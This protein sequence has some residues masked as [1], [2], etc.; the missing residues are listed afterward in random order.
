MKEQL[1]KVSGCLATA[2]IFS[3]LLYTMR[4]AFAFRFGVFGLVIPVGLLFFVILA[5]KEISDLFSI[6]TFWSM[7]DSRSLAHASGIAAEWQPDICEQPESPRSTEPKKV[8]F[9]GLPPCPP[10]RLRRNSSCTELPQ[11]NA[12]PSPPS[13]SATPSVATSGKPKYNQMPTMFELFASL[14]QKQ[15][16]FDSTDDFLTG[17]WGSE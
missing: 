12:S 3:Y 8:R 4:A 2:L 14:F 6:L 13:V 10:K 11:L 15:Q 7:L 17:A 1:P 16:T 9:V 5:A